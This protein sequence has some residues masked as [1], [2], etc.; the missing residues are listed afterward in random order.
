MQHEIVVA[1][2]APLSTQQIRENVNLIQGV[3]AAVMKNGVHFGA[4]PGCGDKPTLFKAG[5]EK[6]LA[7]FRISVEPEVE[8]L[9][10]ADCAHYRVKTRGMTPGGLHVGTGIG[11]C[12][13]DEEKYRWRFAVCDAEFEA[14]PETRRRLKYKRD[15]TTIKQVRT[16]PADVANTVLKMAK[17]RS[18]VDLC[19]T[20]TAASD[21]FTQDIVDADEE[22]LDGGEAPPMR[23]TVQEPQ[24][25]PAPSAKAQSAP[26][27]RPQGNGTNVTGLV[28]AI[29]SK[30]TSNGG[31]RYGFKICDGWFNT[32]DD[33]LN[34]LATDTKRDGVAVYVEYTTGQYGN[35][36]TRMEVASAQ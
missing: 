22:R 27:P 15:G 10:T 1:P 36:I 33:K 35:D 19:L 3:M 34:T 28:A 25:K 26:A 7:T 13:S 17:K 18:Q 20:A 5:A 24:R 6:I 2:D 11:E 30:P 29:V 21:I 16:A 23:Q 9:S 31:K 32:F 14:Q 8:D 4:I 12:S